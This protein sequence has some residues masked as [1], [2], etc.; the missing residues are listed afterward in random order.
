MGISDLSASALFSPTL[1]GEGAEVP[2]FS[3]SF[4]TP[5]TPALSRKRGRERTS[6]AA[7]IQRDFTTV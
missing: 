3:A 5:T 4:G 7:P 1:C 6:D 2:T